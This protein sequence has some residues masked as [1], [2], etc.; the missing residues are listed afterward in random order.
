MAPPF[1][2]DG[3]GPRFTARR[4]CGCGKGTGIA[5][6]GKSG[7]LAVEEDVDGPLELLR[8]SRPGDV[9]KLSSQ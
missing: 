8:P 2:A 5:G 9:M 6:T 7:I 1:R 3:G 4:D